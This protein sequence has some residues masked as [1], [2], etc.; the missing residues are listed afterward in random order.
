MGALVVYYSRT[1]NTKKIGEAIAS[2]LDA[3]VEQ[4]DDVKSRKGTLGYV[5]SGREATMKSLPEITNVKKRPVDYDLVVI[6]TPVWAFTMASPIR[7][8]ITGHK[9]DFKKVAFFATEGG[10]GAE[11]AFKEMEKIIGKKPEAVVV[12]KEKEVKEQNYVN[13][14]NEFA[15]K[16][17]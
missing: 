1:G 17:K 9:D 4:I 3:D 2:L 16:L 6:G 10:R 14:V 7:T 13:K 15:H 8:Y 12:F 11:N 5:R